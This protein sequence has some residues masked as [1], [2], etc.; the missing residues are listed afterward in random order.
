MAD[1]L[2]SIVS[3][4]WAM[5]VFGVHQLASLVLEPESAA[6]AFE[7]VTT[8]A[9]SELA[10]ASRTILQAGDLLQRR[11]MSAVFSSDES[12]IAVQ[13][14][15]A[16]LHASEDSS[17][18]KAGPQTGNDSQELTIMLRSIGT[19][20]V[21][22]GLDGDPCFVVHGPLMTMGGDRNGEF[23]GVWAAKNFTPRVLVSYPPPLLDPFDRPFRPDE[24]RWSPQLNPTK[25]KW[26]FEDGWLEAAGPALSRIQV[27]AD[28][29]TQFWYSVAAFVTGGGGAYDR[30]RGQAVCLGSSEFPAPPQPL[31]G[32]S[33]ELDVFHVLKIAPRQ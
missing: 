19:G 4:S 23:E 15:P 12:R 32:L 3:F 29:R 2:E 6:K 30:H 20:T 14:M 22:H 5:S 24:A 10:G 13:T 18:L 21:R 7:S 11:M 1:V 26:V 9:R 28:G 33:F 25:A 17:G 8:T 31:E 27:Q 16:V